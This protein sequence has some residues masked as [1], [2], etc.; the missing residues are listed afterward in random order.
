MDEDFLAEAARRLAGAISFSSVVFARPQEITIGQ[1]VRDL[2]V[3]ARIASPDDQKNQV[4]YLP[5]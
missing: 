4:I 1:C 5:L 3:I 2:E